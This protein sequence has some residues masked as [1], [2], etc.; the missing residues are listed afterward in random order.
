MT[1]KN[2]TVAGSGVLG[3]QIAFQAAFHGYKVTVYDISDEVLEKAK[4]KFD[5]LSEAFK[6]D[7][8]A[9]DEQL[10]LTF[11]NLSYSKDL[12]EAVKDADMLIEAVPE[13]PHIKKEFYE[14]LAAVAPEKTIFATNTSTL[15]P[16][17]LAPYTG[18]PNK[19][20][21]LHFAND[22]RI[23]NTAEIMGHSGTDKAVF[24][25]LVSFAKSIGMV[26]LPI[27][28]EQPAY[29]LNSLLVPYLDAALELWGKDISDIQTIDKTWMVATGAPFGPFGF[30]D[31]IGINTAYNIRKMKAEATQDPIKILTAARLKEE[32]LDLGKLGTSSGEGFYKYPNPAYKDKDFLK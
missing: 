2:V 13:N 17:A 26:A 1:I 20:I 18:R 11:G 8:N 12:G 32:F 25:L 7:L 6:K 24:D 5:L 14:K 29:I 28:K 23:Y 9:T 15:L 10:A 30:I 27:Y 16:S 22:I 19:F 4:A 21:A 3:Y 31:T